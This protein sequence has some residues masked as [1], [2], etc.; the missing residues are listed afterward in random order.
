MNKLLFGI[1]IAIAVLQL[2]SEH[3][4]DQPSEE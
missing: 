3:L 2:L 4:P 1:T